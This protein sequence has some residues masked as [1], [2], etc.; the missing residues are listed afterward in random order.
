MKDL[1]IG[2]LL[3]AV[4]MTFIF[5]VFSITGNVTI[6]KGLNFSTYTFTGLIIFTFVA[7]N[8]ELFSRGY[9]LYAL[10]EF[11]SEK[12]AVVVSSLIFA[13]LHVFNPNLRWFGIFNIF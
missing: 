13:L 11:N 4:S 2:L 5:A 3:G 7:L 12:F 8:E 1:L 10:K 6:E 9:C